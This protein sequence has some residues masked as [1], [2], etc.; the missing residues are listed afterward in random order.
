[1]NVAL[2]TVH[3][4]DLL[5]GQ[6]YDIDSYFNP[7]QDCNNNWVLTEGEIND[8]IYPEFDWIEQLPLIEWCSPPPE[9][10]E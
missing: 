5:V 4:K 2:L 8:N 10:E 3:E 9:D 7:V 6:L 1:M